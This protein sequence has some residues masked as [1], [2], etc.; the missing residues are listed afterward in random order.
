MARGIEEQQLSGL[1][2]DVLET[3]KVMASA[4][5]AAVA[6]KQAITPEVLASLLAGQA[7]AVQKAMKPENTFHPNRSV[8]NPFGER[9][10]PRPEFPCKQV[11]QN[12]IPFQHETTLFEEC[13]LIRR[14]PA[15]EFIVTK[16]DGSALPLT[17]EKVTNRANGKLERIQI[18]YPTRDEHRHNHRSLFEYGLEV[19][20]QAGE[21]TD[22]LVALKREMDAERRN[23]AA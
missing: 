18:H 16:A 17:I 5:A 13:E 19:L 9:E 2:P 12:G 3:V 20:T 11:L 7:Q 23:S 1:S 22:D 10:R 4:V 21:P 8:Y 14:L 6:E 15:G